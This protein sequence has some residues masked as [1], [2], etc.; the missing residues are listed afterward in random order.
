MISAN[1]LK[2]MTIEQSAE[3]VLNDL[4]TR[5]IASRYI[6]GGYN[7]NLRVVDLAWGYPKEITQMIFW[8]LLM[9]GYDVKFYRL[10]GG[11]R[12]H[13]EYFV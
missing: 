6:P 9:S 10:D 2:T 11:L 3:M 1:E 4:E 7:S 13:I 5:I 8:E 12:I